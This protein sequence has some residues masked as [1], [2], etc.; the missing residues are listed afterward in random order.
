MDRKSIGLGYKGHSFESN[1]IGKPTLIFEPFN[2]EHPKTYLF[3][4]AIKLLFS[5]FYCNIHF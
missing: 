1:K 5:S 2:L 3:V 4:L